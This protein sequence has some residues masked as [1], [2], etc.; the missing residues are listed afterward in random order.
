[1]TNNEITIAHARLLQAVFQFPKGELE[2]VAAQ[3]TDQTQ[4]ALRARLGELSP[5]QERVLRQV[6]GIGVPPVPMTA[7]A[8]EWGT[9]SDRVRRIRDKALFRLRHKTC[10]GPL[11]VELHGLGMHFPGLAEAVAE[12]RQFEAAAAAGELPLDSFELSTRTAD[13]LRRD[14]IT[15]VA[16]LLKKTEDELLRVPRFGRKSLREIKELCASR[17]WRLRGG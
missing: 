4:R 1:M 6:Y 8:R 13:A 5:R 3:V 10:R 2:T 16:Q 11:A 17:G 12:Q 7:L 14:G 15:T 9:T